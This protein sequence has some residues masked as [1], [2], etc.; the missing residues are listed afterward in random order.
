VA[1][2]EVRIAEDGEILV[3]GPQ[4]MKGYYNR[5]EETAEAIDADGWFHT[6]DVGEIDEDGFLRITDRKK[7][8]IVTAGGR[9]S[10]RSPS[11]TG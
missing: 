9:T 5:P 7:D 8:I 1:G 2:T 10:R 6:G 3:R 4:V 11:R